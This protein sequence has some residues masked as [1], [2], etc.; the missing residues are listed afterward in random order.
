[1]HNR[2]TCKHISAI[3]AMVKEKEHELA[4]LRRA[5]EQ[6]EEIIV[7]VYQEK[8]DQWQQR[9]KVCCKCSNQSF[10]NNLVAF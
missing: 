4:N 5:M 9:L 1:M 2:F 10:S 3:Q 7:R 6:N 8:E